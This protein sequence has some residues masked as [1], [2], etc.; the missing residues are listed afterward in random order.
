MNSVKLVTDDLVLTGQVMLGMYSMKRMFINTKGKLII[1]FDNSTH[2]VVLSKTP[3]SSIEIF[4]SLLSTKRGIELSDVDGLALS[5][6]L[7]A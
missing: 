2:I 7:S 1:Q 4:K 6:I 5:H 3:M